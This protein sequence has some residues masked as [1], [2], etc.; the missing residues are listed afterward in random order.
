MSTRKITLAAP[1]TD[2]AGKEH[3]ADQTVEL[4]WGEAS[5]LLHLGRAREAE[6]TKA[7]KADEKKGA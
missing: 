3:K 5:N 2:R 4:P 6:T 1:Y 7:A